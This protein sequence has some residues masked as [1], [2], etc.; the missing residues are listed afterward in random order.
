[1]F[2]NRKTSCTKTSTGIA[3]AALVCAHLAAGVL[4]CQGVCHRGSPLERMM[5]KAKRSVTGFVR[6]LW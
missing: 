1:M 3:V 2:L 5:K 4:L 6:E